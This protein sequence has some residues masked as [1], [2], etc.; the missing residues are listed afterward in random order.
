MAVSFSATI[1]SPLGPRP[2]RVT[3]VPMSLL[4]CHDA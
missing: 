2:T 4:D 1:V 3:A